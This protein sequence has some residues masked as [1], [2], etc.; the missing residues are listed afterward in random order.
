MG[1]NVAALIMAM[2]RPVFS[3]K[4]QIYAANVITMYT[5]LFQTNN[6]FIVYTVPAIP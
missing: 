4:H 3:N 2:S 1:Y 5:A 6:K